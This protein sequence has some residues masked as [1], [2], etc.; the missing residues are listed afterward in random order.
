M[1][2]PIAWRSKGRTCVRNGHFLSVIIRVA[3]R[4]KTECRSILWGGNK[5]KCKV[6]FF[7]FI[8]YTLNQTKSNVARVCSQHLKLVS[9]RD[10]L[11]PLDSS[12]RL[13][14]LLLLTLLLAVSTFWGLKQLKNIS[15]AVHYASL[16]SK[17]V[18]FSLLRQNDS[19]FRAEKVS[20]LCLLSKLF[21]GIIEMFA[22]TKYIAGRGAST[23][24]V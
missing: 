10:S 23:P 12:H 2:S 17:H 18:Y 9:V 20:F 4:A 7:V 5:K 1:K 11:L 8:K 15:T 19:A 13:C 14:Y 3:R 22:L 6:H 24:P 16:Q 21:S